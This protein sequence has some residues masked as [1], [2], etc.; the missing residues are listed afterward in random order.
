MNFRPEYHAE[1]MGK[2]YYQQLPLA[3]LGPEATRELLADLL[4][5]DPSTQGLAEAIHARTAG[6][7][8]FTEEVVQSL[9]ESGQLEG[10]RGSYRLVSEL[11]ALEVPATVQAVVAAR[12]DRLPEREKQV[13]AGGGGDRA[14]VRR[15][16]AG[17][18]GRASR[19]P[20]WR[21]RCGRS[22]GRSSSTSSRST[23]WR[24]TPSSI[25]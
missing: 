7:P 18:G 21:S 13:L 10:T 19:L 4:G 20:I 15:A 6:N 1:W 14:G 23:R 11:A 9:I 3:P 22:R 17:G 25:R 24:S 2:S 8:F 5:G 12:I 16:G